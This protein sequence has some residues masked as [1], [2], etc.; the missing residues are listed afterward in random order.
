MKNRRRTIEPPPRV[1]VLLFP[2]L[3]SV[4]YCFLATAVAAEPSVKTFELTIPRAAADAQTRVL[5]VEKGD[6][7]QLRFRS[8]AAGEIHFHA[9]RLDTKVAPGISVELSFKARA[10]G[11]FR[12]EWHP[13]GGAERKG[14]HASPLATL[15]VRPK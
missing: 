12:I 11:R 13:A 15:E 10:T 6:L 4:L 2:L 7:V 1:R 14:H 8:E 3:A 5:R 9:Y